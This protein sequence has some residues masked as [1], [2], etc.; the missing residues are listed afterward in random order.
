MV[1]DF[2]LRDLVDGTC[3]GE[4]DAEGASDE[5]FPFFPPLHLPPLP[6]SPPL[7]KTIFCPIS[8][9][10]ANI[11]LFVSSGLGGMS[12][13]QPKAAKIAG[14]ISVIA[15]VNKKACVRPFTVPPLQNENLT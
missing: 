8:V 2:G 1:A 9:I 10:S 13:A 11:K 7:A 5:Y 6:P 12:G 4:G 15:E 14:L 3:D